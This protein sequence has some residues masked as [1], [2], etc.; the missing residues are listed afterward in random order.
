MANAPAM[1][2][3]ECGPLSVRALGLDDRL[4]SGGGAPLAERAACF[5]LSIAMLLVMKALLPCSFQLRL[6]I[7]FCWPK[8][9]APTGCHVRTK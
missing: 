6:C 4:P 9:F 7:L 5:E 1:I 3:T 8:R 2:D